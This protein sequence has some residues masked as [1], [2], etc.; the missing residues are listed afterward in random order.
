MKK[1]LK[2]SAIVFLSLL[3]FAF[4]IP[5]LFKSKIVKLVKA[6]INNNIN[7]KVDFKDVNISLFR[8]FPKLSVGLDDIS[9]VGVTEFE[10]DTLL[11][12]KRM[13]ASVNLWSAIRG[14]DIEVYGVFLQSPRIHALVNKDGRANWEITKDDSTTT[15]VGAETS[16]F[17]VKLEKYAIEN[18]YI[19][20]KDETSNMEAEISGLDHNGS[21]DI[22]SEVFTLATKTKA[23]SANFSYE[24][25]PYLISAQTGIDADIIIDNGKSKY[26]FKNADIGINNLKLTADG[27]VQ[28]DNDSTYSMD[29]KFAALS[30]EFKNFLS[31]VP[32]VYK[33][34]F[35][36]LKTSGTASFKGYAKGA[37]SPTQLPSFSV[38]LNIKDGV[39]QYPDLPQ[40]VKN[41]NIISQISNKDGIMDHTV[42]DVKKGHLEF[43]NDPIDFQLIFTNPETT[44]FIDAVI[45]GNVNL[46]TI[47]RFVK[48][49]PATKL[50]GFVAADAFVKGRLSA[51]E[52]QKGDFKAGVFFDVTK[53]YYSSKDFPRRIQN[54]SFIIQIENTRGIADAT[55]VNV[56]NGHVELGSDP[57]DFS[58]Q[59]SQPVSAINFAGAAKGRFTLDNI[60]QF[61][62]LPEG[63][64]IKGLLDADVN[65][66]GSKADIDKKNYENINT[67]GTLNFNKVNYISKEYPEGVSIQSAQLKFNPQNVTL[68]NCTAHF[69]N[70]NLTADG[71]L[72]NLI[73]YAL[74]K[75]ELKGV[76]NI[77]ADK[78]MLNEWMGTTDTTSS[79]STSSAPFAVPADVNITVNARANAVHYDK[80]AYNNVRGAL[81]VK[82]ETVQLQNVQ[83]DALDGSIAFNGSYSTKQN[84]SNPDISLSYDVKDVDIQKAFYAYNTMQKLMPVGRFL[85]GKLSSQFSMIGK[86]DDKMFPDLSTLTGNGNLLLIQGIL[87]KFQPLDKLV[88]AL[89][90][91]ELKDVTVKDIKSHFEFANGKVLVKPFN[92]K[93]N[94]IDMQIGGM[95]GFDQSIDYIIGMKLPRKYLG[96]NGNALVNNLAAQ[97]NNKGIPVRLSDVI[98]LNIKMGGSITNPSIK[99][100]LK[101]SA[102]DVT[103]ELKQQATAFVQ[104]KTEVTKQT[105]KDTAAVIKNQVINDVKGELVKQLTGS[106]DSSNKSSL[107]DTKQKT[108][109]TIKNTFG[110]FLKK[111]KVADS[112]KQN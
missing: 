34:D 37:Y 54:G 19:F 29:L 100:D 20:Y 82:D 71:I 77:A 95:H 69:K 51:L 8:H 97:A 47:G 62:T 81:V 13:D 76:L 87:N 12:A 33:T 43:G 85:S 88:S 110:G 104:Q 86:L 61:T 21:G 66:S 64:S 90:V 9:V 99:T 15:S 59:L 96:N 17:K 10:K 41:I 50:S 60:H 93:I 91:N 46:S 67:S 1:I 63:T 92:V 75:Q 5:V 57:F 108:V 40:P 56:S 102:G 52:K 68:N 24:G 112:T 103:K 18:G 89:D 94:D 72:D 36:K 65:F 28:I 16:S 32:A 22:T 30:N 31:L 4:L 78:I 3:L 39:F 27:F 11:S 49:D 7:A 58:L 84:K 105:L 107:S 83:T 42:V 111:K 109:E 70:T 74:H 6:E 79:S 80:V 98:D 25:I 106:K 73:G 53:L 48:L 23:L 2:Y 44:Q 101:Q 26:S 35:D 14:S 38:D 55:T 45:K